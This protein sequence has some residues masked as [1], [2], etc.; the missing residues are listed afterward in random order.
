LNTNDPRLL[1]YPLD[2]TKELEI[3]NLSKTIADKF[4]PKSLRAVI[5][6]AGYLLPEKSIK[7]ID[8][9]IVQQ[10]FSV[11]TIGPM[12]M[13]KHLSALLAPPEKINKPFSRSLW[14]NISAKTGSISDNHLGGW[15]SYRMS[16]AAL[17]QLTKTLA[18]ELGRK[19]VTTVSLHPGT[20]ETDLSR[21]YTKNVAN[22][23][24]AD[25]SVDKLFQV[26]IQLK[27]EQNGGFFDYKGS[28]IP[29]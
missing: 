10:H 20:V 12:F 13:A 24:T 16:K 17:N 18:I 19:G 5:N 26:L 4:G 29:F 27:E 28:S 1:F 22:K 23:M 11:N 9:S 21:D 6:S 8:P 7:Q 25:Q 14:I 2:V 15:Y 3:Q